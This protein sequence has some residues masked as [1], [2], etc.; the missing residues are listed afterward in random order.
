LSEEIDRMA[1]GRW[2]SDGTESWKLARDH[3]RCPV[4]AEREAQLRPRSTLR[5][6]IGKPFL[7]K[8]F[9]QM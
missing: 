4:T 3:L 8:P 9:G 5:K 6:Q 1:C 7:F 2:T